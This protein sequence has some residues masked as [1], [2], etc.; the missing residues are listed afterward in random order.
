MADEKLSLLFR[1]GTISQ[2]LAGD[3]IVPGAVSF[4]T[5]EPGIYLDL[6]AEEG[7][8]AAKRVRVGDFITV[9]S[10]DVIKQQA[11]QAADPDKAFSEHCLYYSIQENALMKYNKTTKEFILINDLGDLTERM[12][13]AEATIISHGGSIDTLTTGLANEIKRAGDAESA[14]SARID[15]LTGGDGDELSLVSLSAALAAE[16]KA[17]E[18]AD[19]DL[20]A[21]I[22]GINGRLDGHDTSIANLQ[23]LVGS[24]P[25]GVTGNIWQYV[26]AKVLAEQNR[27]DTEEKRLAGLISAN[28][29][30]IKD[31]AAAIVTET[32]R[33]T[34][35]EQANA[36]AAANAMAK[37]EQGVTAAANE[38]ARAL[39]AEG[40]LRTD[41]TELTTKHNGFEN[42]VTSDLATI[43]GNIAT[44]TSTAD[45]ALAKANTNATAIADEAKKAREEEGKIAKALSDY[46][47]EVTE[48]FEEVATNIN[49]ASAAAGAVQANLDKEVERAQQA[50][51]ANANAIS[52]V[53]TALEQEK[54][55]R[56]ADDVALGKRI[57]AADKAIVD[58]NG[59]IDGLKTRMTNAENAIKDVDDLA[60]ANEKAI[61]D[62]ETARVNAVNALND[63][64]SGEISDRKKEISRVETLINAEVSNRETAITEALADAAAD[65]KA[66]DDA[67]LEVI[68]ERMAA[69][70]SMKFMGETTSYS[71]L[72][73][74]TG[75]EGKV[76]A[77]WTYVVKTA[78][79]ANEGDPQI[80]DLLVA[81]ADQGTTDLST[82][83]A[84][85]NFF[86]HIKTGYSTFNDPV[87]VVEDAKVKMKSHL[88][89]VLGTVSV[90]SASDNITAS[91]T[92]SGADAVINVG[93]VWGTF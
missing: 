67:L 17:R 57:D 29:A 49:A 85:K 45:S 28:D 61:S 75:P 11:A 24:L 92:G 39:E 71:S 34:A 41:L 60:Q 58:A 8:G 23:T 69:A 52:E 7:G 9:A 62:E 19:T 32:G 14:L 1:R 88:G 26:D 10:F 83:E 76:E 64:I 51:Q 22:T 87:L 89:E 65:A 66:K 2:I 80:G 81:S 30:A 13:A 4:C 70:N 77:G 38:A 56:E 93:L 42:T 6:T 91:I 27:A 21:D 84:K 12:S 59:A 44:V 15:A 47:L 36:T 78:F 48:E 53:D 31:N 72:P 74:G 54:T 63:A 37:A 33:A 43:N 86:I 35:A 68:N 16:T 18:D 46:K 73:D 40:K 55:K 3:K 50:E 82:V 79:G 20:A 25:E 5:D 90:N